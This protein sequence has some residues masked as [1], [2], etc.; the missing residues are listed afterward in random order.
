MI[1]CLHLLRVSFEEAFCFTLKMEAAGS[2]EMLA[3]GYQNVWRHFH[4][5]IIYRSIYIDNHAK[6]RTTL[7]GQNSELL[8]L[9]FESGGKLASTDL[10]IVCLCGL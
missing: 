5:N 9:L 7:C 4:W 3:Y 6:I 2:T 8:V 1:F 10:F